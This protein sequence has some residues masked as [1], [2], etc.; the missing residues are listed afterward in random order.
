MKFDLSGEPIHTRCLAIAFTQGEANQIEFRADIIDL[1][2][3]GL[4]ELGG[5]IATA[6]IIHKME[7]RGAFS[8]ESYCLERIEWAQ[9]HVMHEANSATKGESCRDPMDRLTS[10]VGTPLGEGFA[11]T[12]KQCFGG[13]LGC[14]HINTLFQE[15]SAFVSRLRAER[16]AHQELETQR[17][18]GDRIAAR[19]VYFDAFHPEGGA[20]ATISVRLSD[21]HYAKPLG[22][23]RERLH[24]HDELR[25]LADVELAGWKLQAAEAKERSRRGPTCGDEEWT[26]RTDELVDFA[27]RSLGG[28]MTR[29]CLERLGGRDAD[30]R[31][32]STL[33]S[34]APGMTQVGVALSDGLVPQFAS[35]SGG[36]AGMGPG[37]CYMLR[38][39]GPLVET[40]A[41][42]GADEASTTSD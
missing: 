13:P 3:A 26:L 10:L 37:P 30:A 27:G 40:F 28:G 22:S 35:E 12:L 8:E 14:T 34:L 24:A 7:L 5:R 38:S 31:L 32:L 33:L 20:M 36:W 41:A 9:S 23:G 16:R 11:A 19:S 4:M 39:D 25:L 15:L 18:I 29:F 6:G 17:S 42:G 1:R 2:K 21:I